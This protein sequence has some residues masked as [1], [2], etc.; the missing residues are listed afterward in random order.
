MNVIG[1][2]ISLTVADVAASAEFFADCLEFR[3]V[4]A[5]EGFV[6]LARDDAAADI[7]LVQG[8]SDPTAGPAGLAGVTVS[9]LVTDLADEVRRLQGAGVGTTRLRREPWGEWVLRLTDPNGVRI[10][11]AEWQP[12]GGF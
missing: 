12:P 11:L 2:V 10:R 8:D 1:S 6:C 3:T 9:F 5:G 4:V 7:L